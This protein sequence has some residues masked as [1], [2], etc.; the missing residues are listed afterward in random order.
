MKP[1]LL[2]LIPSWICILGVF[3]YYYEYEMELFSVCKLT[4]RYFHVPEPK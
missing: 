3:T 4:H 1:S 2:S